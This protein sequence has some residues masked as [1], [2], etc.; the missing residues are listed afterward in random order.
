MSD[1]ALA[2]AL[3]AVDPVGTGGV[4]LRSAWGPARDEWLAHLQAMLPPGASGP[5]RAARTSPTIVCWAVSILRRRCRPERP[6]VERGLL[7]EADGGLVVVSMAERLAPSAVAHLAA[8]LDLACVVV[9]RDGITARAAGAA[10]PDRP[11]RRRDG[12]RRRRSRAAGSTGLS[13]RPCR[14]HGRRRC[15]TACRIVSTIESARHRLAG[16]ACSRGDRRRRSARRPWR[17]ASTS[18]RAPLLALQVARA[19]AALHGR[20]QVGDADAVIACRL[21]LAPRATRLPSDAS[22]PGAGERP[23]SR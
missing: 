14:Q 5:A 4:V 1:A 15:R 6:I 10:W 8:A 23:T 7:A 11:R 17:W 2:A 16:V 13:R 9:E 21:V 22:P 3:F 12:G 18:L 20:R 19:S